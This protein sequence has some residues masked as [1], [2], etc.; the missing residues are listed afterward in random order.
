MSTYLIGRF[1]IF[2]SIA[3]IVRPDIIKAEII[4]VPTPNEIM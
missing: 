4:V 3:I 1:S 2:F